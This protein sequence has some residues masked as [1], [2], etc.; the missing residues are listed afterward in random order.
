MVLPHK[1]W[2]NS[3]SVQD[4]N[5]S[6]R[7]QSTTTKFFKGR[8]FMKKSFGKRLQQL[9]KKAGLTQEKLADMMNVHFN[10]ISLWENDKNSPRLNEIKEICKVLNVSEN[11]LLSDNNS[12]GGDEWV[13]EIKMAD[14]MKEFFDMT[15]GMP[16][17]AQI[18]TNQFG[19]VLHL[20]GAYEVFDNDS[21]FNDFI[22]QLKSARK[23]IRQAGKNF[24][25]LNNS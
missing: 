23:F 5:C 7:E 2:L 6:F 21:K 18:L 9:R 4:R 16:C 20:A 3:M 24:G 17:V 13:L 15:D 12:N 19:G 10:T 14:N 11:E 1:S 8:C 22:K 25:K